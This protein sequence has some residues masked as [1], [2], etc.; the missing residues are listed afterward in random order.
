M[1]KDLRGATAEHVDFPNQSDQ[2][3]EQQHTLQKE[4][5]EKAWRVDLGCQKGSCSKGGM[6]SVELDTAKKGKGKGNRSRRLVQRGKSPERKYAR[7]TGKRPSGKE[8]RPPCCNCKRGNCSHDR[9]RGYW[10]LP[11]CKYFQKDKCQMRM[12]C[13]FIHSHKKNLSTGPQRKEEGKGKES[14]EEKVTIDVVNFANRLKDTSRKPLQ[15]ETSRN[16]HLKA[17]GNLE[18][19]ARSNMPIKGILLL[20]RKLSSDKK[21]IFHL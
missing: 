12:G 2:E 20:R 17:E 10:H 14:H 21:T 16:T 8:D 9:E 15:V 19:V 13:S 4:L 11:H 3:T 6:C 5:K 7:K 18:Q 1:V